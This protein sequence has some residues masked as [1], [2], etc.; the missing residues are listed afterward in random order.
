MKCCECNKDGISPF[1]KLGLL[2]GIDFRCSQC[3]TE[4]TL[5]KG[6]GFVVSILINISIWFSVIFAF[7]YM[8]AYLAYGTLVLAF[9]FIGTLV[10]LLPLKVKSRKLIKGHPSVISGS[11]KRGVR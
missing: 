10:I 11:K 2:A 6:F 1:K 9:V 4:F 8:A 5:N 7:Y 3:G